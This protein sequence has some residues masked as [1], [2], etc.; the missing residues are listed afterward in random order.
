MR[1]ASPLLLA[2][3]ALL[4]GVSLT[5]EAQAQGR[6]RHADTWNFGVRCRMQWNADAS[7]FTASVDPV[8]STAEGCASFSNPATG[9][10]L[11]YSDGTTIWRGDGT[12]IATGLAGNSSSLHSAVVVPRPLNPNRLFIITHG[13]S[14]SSTVAFREINLAPPVTAVGSNVSRTLDGGAATGR[15][16]MVVIPHANGTDYWVVVSGGSVVFV[17]P[18]TSAGIGLPVKYSTGMNVSSWNVFAASNSGDRLIISDSGAGSMASFAFN[19]STGQISNKQTLISYLNESYYGGG[20]SPDDTKFYFSTLDAQPDRSRYGAFYQYNLSNGVLTNLS[21][22]MPRYSHGQAQL[23]PDG[24]IYVATDSHPT[25]SLAVVNNPNAAGVAC[26]FQYAPI[27]TAAGCSPRLGLP[28]SVSPS[29]QLNFGITLLNPGDKVA[30]STTT[31]SGIANAPN[32]TP[33]QV[34]VTG[35][36]GYSDSCTATVSSG[37]WTCANGSINGL[38]EGSTYNILARITNIADVEDTGTFTVVQCLGNND[39]AA[40]TPACDVSTNDCVECLDPPLWY[41]DE[42]SDGYG[43][44]DVSLRACEA[45]FG[46]VNNGLDC[47]DFNPNVHPNAAERCDNIDNDCDG[48]IDEGVR[49]TLYRDLDGDGFGAGPA[50]QL[51]AGAPNVSNTNTDCNDNNGAINPNAT[52]VCDG[53]DN[54]CA[55]GIDNSPADAGQ[56]CNDPT[57]VNCGPGQTVCVDG[58]L[59]CRAADRAA[60]VCDGFD[61]DC[62]GLIDEED[63]A[64]AAH[65]DASIVLYASFDDD[66]AG[67]VND[68]A[69]QPDNG[70]LGT[71]DHQPGVHLDA[72][73][74]DAGDVV[75]FQDGA[76]RELDLQ[77][78]RTTG[79]T[80]SVWVKPGTLPLNTDVFLMERPGQFAFTLN[81]SASAIRP[82]LT[83]GAVTFQAFG[84]FPLDRWTHLAFV[85]TGTQGIWFI[86]GVALSP[87]NQQLPTLNGVFQSTA[88]GRTTN[89]YAGLID[90]LI[91]WKGPQPAEVIRQLAEAGTN[92]AAYAPAIGVRCN[93][94]EAVCSIGRTA[95]DPVTHQVTCEGPP[96]LDREVC[97]GF[98]NDCDG[99]ID[100]GNTVAEGPWGAQGGGSCRTALPGECR[101][102]RFLCEGGKLLCEPETA[103]TT[104]VCDA[105]DNDCDGST[106]ETWP[107]QNQACNTGLGGICAQGTRECVRTGRNTV[108]LICQGPQPGNNAEL[109]NGADDDC[110]GRVD[111]GGPADLNPSNQQLTQSCGCGGSQTCQAGAWS[112][113][114]T[115]LPNPEV[116]DGQ[117]ND[118]DSR[119]DEDLARRCETQCG[120]GIETCQG[121]GWGA[122]SAPD[123]DPEVC[124]GQDDD[125]DGDFDEGISCGCRIYA[126]GGLPAARNQWTWFPSATNPQNTPFSVPVGVPLIMPM[127]DTNT[128]GQVNATDTPNIIFMTASETDPQ[129][130]ILRVIRGLDGT[131]RSTL[132]NLPLAAQATPAIADVNNNGFPEIAALV[133]PDQMG[134]VA[135][136]D[137]GGTVLWHNQTVQP[138]SLQIPRGSL[139][140]GNVNA[141]T[142]T[143]EIAGCH[144]LVSATGQTLWNHANEPRS[145]YCSPVLVDLNNDGDLEVLLGGIA[146]NPD[147]TVLWT[148]NAF[149]AA[150]GGFAD[151]FTAAAD[152]DNDGDLEVVVV[153]RDIYVLNGQTGAILA[154][155]TV[156]GGGRGGAPHIADLDLDGY[157]DIVVAGSSRLSAMRYTDNGTVRTLTPR[158]SFAIRD[159]SGGIASATSVDLNNDGQREVLFADELYLYILSSDGVLYQDLDAWGTRFSHT[160]TVADINADDRAEIVFLT[161][162]FGSFFDDYSDGN[163]AGTT[164][165]RVIA[166]RGDGI[167]FP[168]TGR[169]WNQHSFHVT[170]ITNDLRAPISEPRFWT[171]ADT[172]VFRGPQILNASGSD[173]PDLTLAI[174]DF[175]QGSEIASAACAAL[176]RLTVEIC[177]IGAADVT[178]VAGGLTVELSVSPQP[179]G[180][181]WSERFPVALP[182]VH[183]APNNCVVRELEFTVPF[184]DGRLFDLIAAIDPVVATDG[185]V[186][187]C[188]PDNNTA[189]RPFVTFTPI[190]PEI[191]DGVDNDCDGQIDRVAGTPLTRPCNTGC[192][193]TQ[194]CEDGGWGDCSAPSAGPEV[195]DGKDNNCDG[196]VDNQDTACGGR[197]GFTCICRDRRD[198]ATCGC[199]ETLE[200]NDC[201]AGC[202]LG[203][204]CGADGFCEPGCFDDFGC[205]EGFRCGEDGTCE[206]NP[207]MIGAVEGSDQEGVAPAAQGCSTGPM[208]DNGAGISLL[209]LV[210]ALF[211]M[212]VALRR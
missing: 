27:A 139:A 79:L 118:C 130:G 20:F 181:P 119:I 203:S 95:C 9:D 126:S 211:G 56:A 186:P 102:G 81:R 120:E 92:A 113:C 90:D 41:I 29:V 158:W 193:G 49:L 133:H 32:G 76:A 182:L 104:E 124:N 97:D 189:T 39:C 143:A 18:V 149:K 93:T 5:S 30:G 123:P 25:T 107:E 157:P 2:G 128:S 171:D 127:F 70:A 137:V 103:P 99:D 42:D 138:A 7:A 12:T 177:N 89:G 34:T 175:D 86:N 67:R 134:G 160:P 204:F 132:G 152:L 88:L 78:V 144:W 14:A 68:L 23:A 191:C 94:G 165:N 188:R 71:A 46:F 58:R 37:A 100:E 105:L 31:P 6:S 150:N 159:T 57:A 195:C 109:C 16:G 114:N 208:A 209:A 200:V 60:E 55:G 187:E 194:Q 59:L 72:L 108:S 96:V 140:I 146:Y 64:P 111:E 205:P 83:F 199:V 116:C 61:N 180:G 115:R 121:G 52:E 202:P 75:R 65:N 69:G 161:N 178:A 212:V 47:D 170:N 155:A 206:E 80:F 36:G 11:V 87:S 151:G 62:D 136:M 45:P 13:A 17:L 125:C 173:A 33:I 63:D 169:L 172:H 73:S 174:L 24:K 166:L 50:L 142:P 131:L 190:G 207:A 163:H 91:L 35:P 162:H 167:N 77:G 112:A 135:L 1:H 196:V 210:G 21:R 153:S 183:T 53:L 51:C 197:A 184:N 176:S 43:D 66:A 101:A 26:D 106:D 82:K 117:D 145:I 48:Q 85:H 10:L 110:D 147:G 198:P 168:L 8:I 141:S 38:V 4:L 156:P 28:Q 122:C 84:S 129:R 3:L 179:N 74:L 44:S 192:S 98:D 54:D 201:G 148:S 22:Q 19:R 15:E 154:Q 40:P 164:P 185:L